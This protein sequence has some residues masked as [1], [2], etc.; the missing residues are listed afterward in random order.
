MAEKGATCS[1]SHSTAP[2]YATYLITAPLLCSSQSHTLAAE[3]TPGPT[4]QCSA[5]KQNLIWHWTSRESERIWH[6]LTQ[7]F[8][9]CVCVSFPSVLRAYAWACVCVMYIGSWC[10]WG[11]MM[12]M[13][14]HCVSTY[15]SLQINV[16]RKIMLNLSAEMW[17]A[18]TQLTE[19]MK[20]L[21]CQL[22]MCYY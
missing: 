16:K 22:H 13:C 6:F 11:S 12:P 8:S 14:F 20:C 19:S 17:L 4:V 9:V 21:D 3:I 5:K 18:S 2:P 10:A 1:L 7:W 15:H